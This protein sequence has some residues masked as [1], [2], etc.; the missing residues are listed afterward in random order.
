M[1]NIQTQRLAGVEGG[2]RCPHWA[3]TAENVHMGRYLVAMMYIVITN[4][5]KVP[6]PIMLL[7]ANHNTR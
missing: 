7:E 6:L 1:I 4:G 2:I 5:I 3:G